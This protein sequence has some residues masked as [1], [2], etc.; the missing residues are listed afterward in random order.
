MKITKFGTIQGQAGGTPS[1]P[2]VW[3]DS[4]FVYTTNATTTLILDTNVSVSSFNVPEILNGK[5]VVLNTSSSTFGPFVNKQNLT[6]VR[7]HPNI[8]VLGNNFS[9]AFFNSRNLSKLFSFPANI[10]NLENTFHSCTNLISSNDIPTIPTTVTTMSNTFNGCVNLV[11]NASSFS[12]PNTLVFLNSTFALNEKLSFIPT[13]PSNVTQ[14]TF[15]FSNCN[16]LTGINNSDFQNVSNSKIL[17]AS[18]MFAN[19]RNLTSINLEV[20]SNIVA[21]NNFLMGAGNGGTGVITTLQNFVFK[22]IPTADS[23]FAFA[24]FSQNAFLTF[25][26]NNANS[27][28]GTTMGG[29]FKNIKTKI[30]ISN[31]TIP[32][33]VTNLSTAFAFSNLNGMF[34]FKNSKTNVTSYSSLF[35][36]STFDQAPLL[37]IPQYVTGG[38]YTILFNDAFRQII[39][40]VAAGSSFLNISNLS[41]TNVSF[42]NFVQTFQNSN[43]TQTLN[44]FPTSIQNTS[45]DSMYRNCLQ[46]TTYV[47]PLLNIS[48]GRNAFNTCSNLTTFQNNSNFITFSKHSTNDGSAASFFANCQKITTTLFVV[49]DN[50]G[51]VSNMF[52][53][54][55]TLTVPA[56]FISNVNKNLNISSLYQNCVSL[57]SSTN[58]NIPRRKTDWNQ[59]FAGAGVVGASNFSVASITI[60][61]GAL[62]INQSSVAPFNMPESVL[63]KVFNG[64]TS[65][66]GSLSLTNANS[67][68]LYSLPELLH[69]TNH[70]RTLTIPTTTYN[71][72]GIFWSS[73]TNVAQPS[74]SNLYY[75]VNGSLMYYFA[76]IRGSFPVNLRNSPFL[77]DLGQSFYRTALTSVGP[78]MLPHNVTTFGSAFGDMQFL[79]TFQSDFG[80]NATTASA[81]FRDCP[82]LSSFTANVGGTLTSP[83]REVTG[84][85]SNSGRNLSKT[86]NI[87][88]RN[89]TNFGMN[90]FFGNTSTNRPNATMTL[91][92]PTLGFN[93]TSN[94]YAAALNRKTAYGTEWANVTINPVF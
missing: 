6:S 18:F 88:T 25:N 21:M 3:N 45:I 15:A 13:I 49:S 41:T 9:F 44:N 57:N 12:I 33:F 93:A 84:M 69:S 17:N 65:Y 75:L 73:N 39:S 59:A 80:H 60:D 72:Y 35:I 31:I 47:T 50:I 94:T 53:N 63:S 67:M 19:C 30:N 46:L 11:Y 48:S 4:D 66:N 71:L 26:L 34:A 8:T 78:N 62:K 28:K 61:L 16:S 27:S 23:L 52:F 5:P 1:W 54:C 2:F 32:D 90:S 82:N 24:N 83:L 70:N 22:T 64:S 74:F 51:D 79:T 86:I 38:P 87:L 55:R 36:S 42:I 76:P 85:F 40:P 56:N 43:V 58:L 81:M 37:N 89:I 7:F 91:R 14:A 10:T 29:Y 92:V 20:P 77:N 68:V